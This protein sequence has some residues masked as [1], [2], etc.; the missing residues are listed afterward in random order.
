MDFPKPRPK[1]FAARWTCQVE[2]F[3]HEITHANIVWPVKLILTVGVQFPP[4]F[5]PFV[6]AKYNKV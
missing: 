1:C 6:D 3:E 4:K 2:V 5:C